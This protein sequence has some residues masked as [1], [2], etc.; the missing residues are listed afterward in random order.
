MN[1]ISAWRFIN[2]PASFAK[3][4]LIGPSGKRICNEMLYGAQIGDLIMK[5]HNGKGYLI[6][7]HKHTKKHIKI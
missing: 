1:S 7:D 3:G 4:I 5:Y 2:P 6:L